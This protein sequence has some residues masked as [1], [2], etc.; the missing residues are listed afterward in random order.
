MQECKQLREAHFCESWIKIGNGKYKPIVVIGDSFPFPEYKVYPM[1]PTTPRA[2]TANAL[3]L[4]HRSEDKAMRSA[5]RISDPFIKCGT[6]QESRSFAE[7]RWR[8][9][10][11]TRLDV[12]HLVGEVSLRNE[13][14][15]RKIS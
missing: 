10:C 12:G 1:K 14:E 15:Q 3:K 9:L 2:R 5:I 13:L 6:W 4:D 7:L 11:V 8:C